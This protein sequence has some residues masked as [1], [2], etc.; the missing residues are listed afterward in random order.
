MPDNA[1]DANSEPATTGSFV[2]ALVTGCITVGVCVL[3]WLVMHNRKSLVRVFQPRTVVA[4][5]GKPAEPLPGQPVSWW[6]KV[7]SLDDT[8]VLEANGPDAYFFLRYLKIFGLYMLIPYL[9]FTFAALLPATAVKPNGGQDGLNMFV[10]GNVRS[11]QLDRH[12]AHFFIALILI[13]YTL[14]LIWHEYNHLM[15]IRLRWLRANSTSLKSR[16]VMLVNVPESMYSAAAIRELAGACGVGG[17]DDPRTSLATDGGPST[18][19]GALMEKSAS[20]VTDVWLSQKVKPVE[21][22]YD[23]RNKECTRLEKGVG[24]LLKTALKNERKGK[25]PVAKG[26][27][28]EESADLPDRYV[29]PKKQPK[30]KQGFLGLFGNKLNLH[31]SPVWIKEKNDEIERLRQDTYPD[32][33]VAFVRFQTQDQAHYFARYAKKGNKRL[34]LLESSIEVVPDDI[35][36]NNVG[37]S[38]PQRKARVAISWALTIGL[39]IV[40][41]FPVAFVGIV[42]NVDALCEKA[43]W[44]AW[45]CDIPGAAL[46]II[47][48]VLPAA[49]MALLY[50]LLPIVLRAMIKQEGQIRTS[51]VEL[52]LF[53]RYWLFWV[54]HGFLIVTLASGLTS[55]LSDLGNQ[56]KSVPTLLA[57]KLP[58]ASIYFLTYVLTANWAAAAKSFARIVPT[59]MWQLRGILAGGT[60]RKAFEQKYKLESLQW[61]TTWPTLCLTI[62]ITIVYS[63][64]QPIIVAVC[65]VA[66]ILLYGSYKY[67]LIWTAKQ[68]PVMETGG[69][70]YVKALRT[71]FVSLYLEQIC[72]AA[73]FILSSRP[74]GSRS[75]SGLA[76]GVILAVTCGITALFQIYIDW[77]RFPK[78]LVYYGIPK[79]ARIGGGSQTNLVENSADRAV[80]AEAQENLKEEAALAHE[81]DDQAN[82]HHFDHPAMWKP[83][84][85]IWNAQDPLGLGQYETNYINS[86]GV[87]SSTE[88]AYMNEKG[89]LRVD[90]SPPDEDWFGEE[91]SPNAVHA[92]A[93][94]HDASSKDGYA[95]QD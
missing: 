41:A 67:L 54:I 60:P 34:R 3:F 30:W 38:G 4:P 92:A 28:N 25:T 90:R 55:A 70:Y 46:G 57:T 69:L 44:L 88:F 78:D 82:R 13:F 14:Y 37:I 58:N 87:P 18:A 94:G 1:A 76:C 89:D 68:P 12:L 29:L 53:S 9:F 56:L 74:D 72:L 15:D 7:F 75:P 33:N 19:Q 63:I 61:S 59:I 85:I 11:D 80:Y 64:I 10:F 27:F 65:L 36:W 71:V 26:Q 6:R 35:I 17:V 73:L 23:A 39:I 43:K 5:D 2:A 24:K 84:P 91:V 45:I 95:L 21:K 86:V 48:G 42:S 32:G 81:G 51:V 50:M 49:L 93:Q 79:G 62:C 22:V 8:N 66:T 20:A 52:R 16:T 47:K 83:M 31:S 40:W 77:F